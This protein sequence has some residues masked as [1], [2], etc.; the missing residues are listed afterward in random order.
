MV[1]VKRNLSKFNFNRGFSSEKWPT[2]KTGEKIKGPSDEF[3]CQSAK[4]GPVLKFNLD[5]LILF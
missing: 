4:N 1:R 5:K 2:L 3:F